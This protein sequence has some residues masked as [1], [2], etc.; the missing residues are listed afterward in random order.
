MG[1]L[2][3]VVRQVGSS[4][5][6]YRAFAFS[7]F[8]FHEYGSYSLALYYFDR[9]LKCFYDR[10]DSYYLFEKQLELQLYKS[11]SRIFLAKSRYIEAKNF[12][13]KLLRKSWLL[14]DAD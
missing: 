14:A 5:L 7:A 1:E 9:T 10:D 2:H 13:F 8:C 11:V 4:T 3:E 12:A 6:L